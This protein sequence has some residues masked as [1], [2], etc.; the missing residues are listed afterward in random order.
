MLRKFKKFLARDV[1]GQDKYHRDL[2]N[3]PDSNLK[4]ILATVES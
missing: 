1:L 4:E 3:L 2:F